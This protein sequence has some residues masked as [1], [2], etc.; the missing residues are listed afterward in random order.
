LVAVERLPAVQHLLESSSPEPTSLCHL[1]RSEASPQ[2]T[3]H[4][5][6]S[7]CVPLHRTT[8]MSFRVTRKK[9]AEPNPPTLLR[10]CPI[11][12]QPHRARVGT[13]TFGFNLRIS[14]MLSLLLLQ[15]RR[16]PNLPARDLHSRISLTVIST[17]AR[18]RPMRRCA[19]WRD[20]AFLSNAS[21]RC[22]SE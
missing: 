17:E 10:G 14:N 12:A 20:P 3:L 18:R 2:A 1:D 21:A 6:K 11:L 4:A 5:V 9:I 8:P 19:Q 7:P 13:L 15:L 22:N 16:H